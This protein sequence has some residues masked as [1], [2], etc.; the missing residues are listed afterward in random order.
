RL[1]RGGPQGQDV[2]A[3]HIPQVLKL[4]LQIRQAPL[5]LPLLR[6]AVVGRAALNDVGHVRRFPSQPMPRKLVPQKLSAGADE[7]QALAVL[8]RA[9]GLP[10]HS[11]GGLVVGGVWCHADGDG[12]LV[13]SAV[14][15]G[16]SAR[17]A[18]FLPP[19]VSSPRSASGRTLRRR[20]STGSRGPRT[21][22]A[23]A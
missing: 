8:L 3:P 23:P 21:L 22:W 6:R 15:A 18:L 10:D 13:Q 2:L 14:G 9:R 12:C 17:H 16:T 4:R 20:R 11:K 19:S 5:D 7:R 1:V